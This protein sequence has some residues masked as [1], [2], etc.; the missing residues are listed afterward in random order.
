MP[1]LQILFHCNF[2]SIDF[3]NIFA[4]KELSVYIERKEYGK[5]IN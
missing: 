4:K 1:I 3:K 5:N 2:F